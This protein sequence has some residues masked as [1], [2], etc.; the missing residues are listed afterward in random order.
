MELGKAF[1]TLHVLEPYGDIICA[2][3]NY[4]TAGSASSNAGRSR[5][6][7][8]LRLY[9]GGGG[10]SFRIMRAGMAK[11]SEPFEKNEGR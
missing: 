7:P 9:F 5:K 4:P 2:V 6:R 10:V 3:D 8:Y 1:H 11:G